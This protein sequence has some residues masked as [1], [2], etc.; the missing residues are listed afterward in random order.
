MSDSPDNAGKPQLPPR[1]GSPAAGEGAEGKPAGAAG[2]WVYSGMPEFYSTAPLP[3]AAPVPAAADA[4]P[5]AETAPAKTPAAKP[6]APP[7]PSAPPPSPPAMAGA[8]A[9]AAKVLEKKQT[10][11]SLASVVDTIEAIIIAL[12]I[13]LTFRAFVVEAFVIPTGSMAPTLL[14]A[15]FKAICP[16]CG[17]EFDFNATVGNQVLGNRGKEYVPERPINAAE[18]RSNSKVPL[19]PDQGDNIYCPNCRYQ[20][21]PT[22]LPQYLALRRLPTGGPNGEQ[23]DYHFPWANNGDRILVLKYLYAVKEPQ[24]WDVIVFKEPQAA[25]S[26]YIKRLVGLPH[27]TVQIINGDIY[28]GTGAANPR[29]RKIQRKPEDIQK[30]LWQLV[31]DN[32]YY[33]RDEGRTVVGSPLALPHYQEAWT[34]PWEAQP[35]EAAADWKKGTTMQYTG[36]APGSL[37]FN[38]SPS[39]LHDYPPYTLNILGYNGDFDDTSGSEA[40]TPRSIVGDLRLEAL[41]TPGAGQPGKAAAITLTLGRPNNCYQFVWDGAGMKLLRRDAK[42][43]FQEV[44][45]AVLGQPRVPERGRAYHLAFNNVDHA[46]QVYINGEKAMTYQEEW[47]AELAA[48]DVEAHRPDWANSRGNPL[49]AQEF[50]R[51]ANSIIRID[52]D[53]A[54]ALSHLKLYRD[55]YYTQVAGG[56]GTGTLENPVQLK[57]DEF[58]ALGDNSR[59]SLDGRMWSQTY[60]PLGDLEL[61]PGIVPRRYLLGK[62]FFVY[63]PAGYR[64]SDKIG[65]LKELPLV[66]NTGNMRIIR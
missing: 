8:G 52:V 22:E 47:N 20:I 41:W 54:C 17:Y 32:D 51:R 61:S 7:T 2:P 4:K 9:H 31:Y 49:D 63:W 26:N 43:S 37:Q 39:R 3:A 48:A 46:V 23:K 13:A 10:D 45:A 16:K 64:A 18:L 66:P 1:D 33:P 57:Q 38:L 12:I 50:R 15:H 24:R 25:D 5:A 62:A 60:E 59:K 30:A 34:N 36:V 58:F 65:V 28:A 27:E 29:E 42:A 53:G 40:N 19:I 56:Q 21:P 6:I 55:L 11:A 44:N 14:G 35:P